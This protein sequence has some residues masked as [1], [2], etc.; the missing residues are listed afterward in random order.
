[1]LASAALGI[2]MSES[3]DIYIDRNPFKA[4]RA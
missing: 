2:T 1:M 3:I 4:E